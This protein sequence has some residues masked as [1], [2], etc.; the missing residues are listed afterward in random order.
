MKFLIIGATGMAGH[1]ILNYLEEKGDEVI[2]TV[3]NGKK[4]NSNFIEGDLLDNH[5]IDTI[6]EQDTD[7]IINCAGVL[8]KSCDLKPAN[9]IFINSYL[10]HKLAEMAVGTNTRIIHLSTDCVFSGKEGAYVEDA[11]RDGETYYDKTKALGE[12]KDDKNLTFRMSIIGPDLSDGGI[13]LLNWFMHQD[14]SVYGYSY[15]FWTGVTTL[16]LAEAIEKAAEDRLTGVYHLV[17]NKRI[18][19]FELLK[20]FNK[21]LRK[22][23][24]HII[25]KKEPVCDKSLINTREDFDFCVPSYEGMIMELGKWIEKHKDQYPKCYSN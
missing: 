18:S 7:F 6:F 22:D 1:M 9:A 20:L 21:Y 13:G 14:T 8:N 19:K 11:P 25:E 5:F 16:T 24:I 10:P 17:N 23:N 15:V 4:T 3:R 12:L 2:S